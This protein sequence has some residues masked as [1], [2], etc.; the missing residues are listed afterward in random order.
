M[1]HSA[2]DAACFN[3]RLEALMNA[4][5][6]R[7][8]GFRIVNCPICGRKTLDNFWICAECGWEYDAFISY[9]K[10]EKSLCNGATP[11]EYRRQ[12]LKTLKER[13]AKHVSIL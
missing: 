11:Q 7:E 12:Y 5:E 6:Y 4:S 10:D 8:H 3:D 2:W 9:D 13:E 1:M